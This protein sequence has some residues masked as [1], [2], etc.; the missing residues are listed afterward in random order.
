M[1]RLQAERERA[2]LTRA[3]LAAL[4]SLHASDLGKFE[5]GRLKP[6]AGQI[7]RLAVVLGVPAARLM[8]E[9]QEAKAHAQDGDR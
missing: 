5:V 7:E 2:G 3:R 8:E 4:A 9:A 1:F 6:Y